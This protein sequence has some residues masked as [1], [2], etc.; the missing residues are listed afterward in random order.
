MRHNALFEFRLPIIILCLICLWLGFWSAAA[1]AVDGA[2]RLDR[3]LQGLETWRARFEQVFSDERG[4]VRERSFGTF[5]LHRPGRFRWEYERPHRQS[6]VA[7]GKR[8]WIY[9][10]ELEQVTVKPLEAALGSTPALLLGGRIDFRQEFNVTDQGKREGLTWLSLAPKDT[11]P[12]YTEVRFGFEGPAL[13]VMEL[14]DNFGQTTRIR[15]REERR[16]TPL[17]QALFAF[18]PPP[19]VDVLDAAEGL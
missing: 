12:Q 1:P 16:N 7:D 6:I 19:G 11:E 13:R 5:Y 2:T 18:T 9:D 17:D 8:I 10:P 4:T 14:H 3:Y 15:F